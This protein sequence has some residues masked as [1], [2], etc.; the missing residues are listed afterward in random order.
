MPQCRIRKV[1]A[2]AMFVR[3]CCNRPQVMW[4]PCAPAVARDVMLSIAAS[5]FE[6]EGVVRFFGR[7]LDVEQPLMSAVVF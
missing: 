4:V 1:D 2:V 3:I 7:C 6:E 5:L